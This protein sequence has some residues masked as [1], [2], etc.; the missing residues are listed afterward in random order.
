MPYI[1]KCYFMV[2]I[3]LVSICADTSLVANS[4]EKA[5]MTC[6]LMFQ[7]LTL[8]NIQKNNELLKSYSQA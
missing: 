2:D 6:N 8:V 3:L 5:I 7:I 4:S 1:T